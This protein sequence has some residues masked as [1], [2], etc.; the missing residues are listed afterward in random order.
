MRVAIL[1][2]GTEIIEGNIQDTNS[3]YI[4]R[5]LQALDLYPA[6]NLSVRD[7][8]QDMLAALQWLTTRAD[9]LII[10]GGLG[11]TEDDMTRE[12]VADFSRH[13][14]VFDD[15]LYQDIDAKF[16]RYRLS[17]PPENQK[18]AY[19]PEGGVV[20]PN[21]LGTAPGFY[22]LLQGC[23]L[24]CFPGVPKELY[25][26]LDLFLTDFLVLYPQ[27][28]STYNIWLRTLGM[29]ESRMDEELQPAC[30]AAG[31]NL[32]TM[33]HIGHVD[34]RF[35]ADHDISDE[36]NTIV[37]QIPAISSRIYS[38]DPDQ[39]LCAVLLELL[40]SRGLR[41]AVAE[42]CTGGMI[43]AQLTEV[44]G[45]SEVFLGGWVAYDNSVKESQLH[46][47]N[48]TLRQWGAVSVQTAREMLQG[49]FRESRADIAISV[50]GIAGPGGGSEEKPVGLVY[51]GIGD[52]RQSWVFEYRLTGMRDR[53]RELSMINSFIMLWDYL[54]G[55]EYQADNYFGLKNIYKGEENG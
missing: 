48:V 51:I 46:V 11:P 5:R 22:L 12:V 34:L 17:M 32:G 4:S 6:I 50:T 52:R 36:V 42:S 49:V 55:V 33:A 9:V 47:S 41:L 40:K 7:D 26:M 19:I 8:R 35:S 29:A 21:A 10:T 43:A 44:P 31:I 15:K 14:L 45:S 53:I 30:A 37:N 24:A 25:P 13:R 27:Q 39:S 3:H 2:I 18:Q 38:R 23:T 1:T 54:Q 20:I 16:R 28:R